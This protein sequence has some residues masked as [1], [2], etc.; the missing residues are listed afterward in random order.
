MNKNR[1][2]TIDILRVLGTFLVILAHVSPPALLLNVRTFDVVLLVFISGICAKKEHCITEGKEY[3]KYLLKRVRRL[4]FPTWLLLS[5]MFVVF[6]AGYTV[7]FEKPFF[8]TLEQILESYLLLD[9]VGYVWI[10]RVYLLIALIAPLL[11]K[12]NLKLSDVQYFLFIIGIAS[13]NIVVYFFLYTN[14][15]NL[16]ITEFLF[17]LLAYGFVVAV[18]MR[19]DPKK[20]FSL[21]Y[22]LLS[23]VGLLIFQILAIVQGK[24]FSPADAKYPPAPYYLFYGLTI[25]MLLY[26]AC[27]FLKIGEKKWVK[28]IVWLS[29]NS[30][31]IYLLHIPFVVLFHSLSSHFIALPW[32]IF[33][34]V[35]IFAACVSTALWEFLQMHGKALIGKKHQGNEK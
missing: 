3:G 21:C 20:K 28:R 19:F 2:F 31:T 22:V 18:S 34:L 11:A 10:V 7:L 1:N 24:G 29:K 5:V 25:S 15:T 14:T 6:W 26:W 4:V 30:F 8:W 16:F 23:M 9:G 33:Y 12:I 17:Y 27:G 13:L 35:I 32:Y